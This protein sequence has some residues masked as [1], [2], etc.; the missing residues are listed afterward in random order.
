MGNVK[1]KIK[2]VFP[3]IIQAEQQQQKKIEIR[4]INPQLVIPSLAEGGTSD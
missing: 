2:I 4:N 3:K 1:Q